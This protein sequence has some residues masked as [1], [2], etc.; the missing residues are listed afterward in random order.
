MMKNILILSAIAL[1]TYGITLYFGSRKIV[2]PVPVAE[3]IEQDFTPVQ[4]EYQIVPEFIFT[5]INGNAHNIRDFKGKTVI[6]NFWAS[7]CAPCIV[8]FPH[9]IEAAHKN[10]DV[11]LI[12]MSSDLDQEIVENFMTKMEKKQNLDF[13]APNIII[14]RDE[15]YTITTDLFGTISLPETILIAP[16]QT[17]R[18]KFIGA[19][20][21]PK[22][23]QDQLDKLGAAQ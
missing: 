15:S 12:A 18:H 4:G 3:N 6:L 2:Q 14:T 19:N 22:E 17:M 16:N 21:T 8:E 20:W 7:W 11:I 5:D 23:L 10:K 9:L 1:A 13:D